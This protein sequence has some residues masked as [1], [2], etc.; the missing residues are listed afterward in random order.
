MGGVPSID[1][2][3]LNPDHTHFVF[4]DT[5]KSGK[6]AWGTEIDFRVQLEHS[7]SK[8]FRAPV[9]RRHDQTWTLRLQVIC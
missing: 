2:A 7:I 3:P 4:V 8:M 9:V 6:A 1:G 5:E